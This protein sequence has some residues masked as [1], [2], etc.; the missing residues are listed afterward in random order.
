LKPKS[1]ILSMYRVTAPSMIEAWSEGPRRRVHKAH[2]RRV[3]MAALRI[4]SGLSRFIIVA[5]LA[6]MLAT[7]SFAAMKPSHASAATISCSTKWRI[8]GGYL[9]M[10][11]MFYAVGMY[12][13]GNYYAALSDAWFNSC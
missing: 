7:G 11:D 13:E 1:V 3:V 5:G 9:A 12:D 10:R 6:L 4:R 2:R 8:A